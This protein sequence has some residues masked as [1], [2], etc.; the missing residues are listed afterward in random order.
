MNGFLLR[1][2]IAGPCFE[3]HKSVIYHQFGQHI[4]SYSGPSQAF[5]QPPI[6]AT[7]QPSDTDKSKNEAANTKS[8]QNLTTPASSEYDDDKLRQIIETSNM[9][10]ARRVERERQ[11][12]LETQLREKK[13]ELVNQKHL[14]QAISKNQGSNAPQH[15]FKANSV[16]SNEE[17]DVSSTIDRSNVQNLAESSPKRDADLSETTYAV[18]NDHSLP[19]LTHRSKPFDI[20]TLQKE[21]S[22]KIQQYR[23]HLQKWTHAK[24]AA[25]QESLKV[26]ALLLNEA[27]GYS[28]IEKQKL[29]VEKAELEIE[30]AREAVRAAKAK[31]EKAI[32]NRSDLQKEINELLT[33]K[34]TWLPADVERFTE[35][36][37][38]DHRNQ[39]EE[40]M[41]K[42]ALDDAENFVESVQIKL[43]ALIL[44][45]YHEEQLWSDKIRQALTWGTW[46]LMGVNIMLFATATF[47]VEPWKRRKLVYA[48]QEEVQQKLDEYSLE[49][50]ELSLKIAPLMI[51]SSE[52]ETR[53]EPLQPPREMGGFHVSVFGIDSWSALR[54]WALS[55]V[56][57]VQKPE[58][59]IFL[60]NKPDLAVFSGVMIALGWLF[61]SL[62]TFALFR[63]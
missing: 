15:E 29:L 5:P 59:V 45:R 62:I 11:A 43:T 35:L 44:T 36:Y 27:T 42:K 21:I 34:H 40:V 63:R 26:V 3:R 60:M 50:H 14:Q 6:S 16:E 17:N 48:F 2:S 58:N 7:R 4:R 33:R 9:S 53:K 20:K 8:G 28:H 47:F 56:A 30:Q 12:Q 13:I 55:L 52:R 37:K 19:S 24:W 54:K 32:Q 38:N 49:L 31:Y 41:C 61:G 46:M 10:A 51:D 25:A 22:D 57:A 1:R 18:K 23:A 39:N